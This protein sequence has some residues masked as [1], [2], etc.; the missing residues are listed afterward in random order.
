MCIKGDDMSISS[1]TIYVKDYITLPC[2]DASWGIAK[3]IAEAKKVRCVC[4]T[5]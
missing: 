4:F 1:S 3:A 2:K 5:I